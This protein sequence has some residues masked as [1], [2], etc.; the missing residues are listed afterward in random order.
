VNALWLG[1]ATYILRSTVKSC[2]GDNSRMP[3]GCRREEPFPN[4]W[5]SEFDG[6]RQKLIC[7][8]AVQ[9]AYEALTKYQMSLDSK[10]TS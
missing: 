2:F 3:L 10:V 4:S 9:E 8:Q 5:E 6:F 1:A 7:K